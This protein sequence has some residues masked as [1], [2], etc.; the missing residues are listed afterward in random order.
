M[1]LRVEHLGQRAD[2]AVPLLRAADELLVLRVPGGELDLELLEAE[3]FE[4]GLGE[5]DARGDLVFDL[6]R[7]AEDVGVVLRKAANAQQAVHGAAALVAIDIAR[8]RHSAAAGRGSSWRVLVDKDVARAVHRLQAVLRVV[9]LHRRVHVFAVVLFVAGDLPELAAHDVRR[10]DHVVAAPDAL[11]AHP[12]FHRLADEAALG[13]P[14]DEARAGD[15]LDGEE[16]ELLAE[17]AVVAR[18]DLFEPLEVGVQ[19]FV[20]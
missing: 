16:V 6:L 7:S 14:E 11:F 3:G 5:V 8:A 19:I 10:E 13:V 4:D 20:R 1:P 2:G 17:H 18:L 9:E 15:L 12:V